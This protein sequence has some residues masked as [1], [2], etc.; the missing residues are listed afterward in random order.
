MKDK[1]LINEDMSNLNED[2]K[3]KNDVELITSY[4]SPLDLFLI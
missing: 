3:D 1:K 2:R 4:I